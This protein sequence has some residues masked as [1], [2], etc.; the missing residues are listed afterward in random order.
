LIGPTQYRNRL[1][2]EA[3]CPIMNVPQLKKFCRGFPGVTETLYQE[4]YNFLV[5]AVGG[6]KFAYFKTSHPERWRFS[7]RVSP[8]RFIELTDVPGVKPARYR[9]RFYWITIVNVSSFPPV[10]LTE[11]VEWSYERAF[12][13]LSKARQTAIRASD[14]L[15][16]CSRV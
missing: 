12:T 16:N 14:R 11:L 13:S 6:K 7:T 8:D 4:P 10:Y 5:Y 2:S 1:P 3:H 15:M 9:G